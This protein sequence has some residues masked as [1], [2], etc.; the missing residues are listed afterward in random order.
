[1]SLRATTWAWSQRTLTPTQKI[2]LLALADCY[3]DSTGQCYPKQERVAYQCEVSTK[4][5]QRAIERFKELELLESKTYRLGQGKG[6]KT[7]YLL[8]FS[9]VLGSDLEETNCPAQTL[10]PTSGDVRGDKSGG[11]D[12]TPESSQE[13]EANRKEQENIK[14]SFERIFKLYRESP[15]LAGQTKKRGLEQFR[16]AIQG[17][18][19][20]AQIERAVSHEVQKRKDADRRKVFCANLPDFWRWVRDEKW[21]DTLDELGGPEPTE[22]DIQAGRIQKARLNGI[23]PKA[24]GPKPDELADIPEG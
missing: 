11:L 10:E 20:V 18:A 1:M 3:N 24:W 23:W 21:L 4:T 22:Q 13:Q 16:K 15:L 9:R 5:V 12:T 17:G 14:E 8:D 2:I 6:S 7:Y 19:D